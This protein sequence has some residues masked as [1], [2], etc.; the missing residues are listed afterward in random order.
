VDPYRQNMLTRV[1]AGLLAA[2]D[3]PY[4]DTFGRVWQ[5][6]RP[7]D[8]RRRVT[9]NDGIPLLEGMRK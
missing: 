4:T 2:P 5:P 3:E 9:T 1:R 7:G 8:R 6:L